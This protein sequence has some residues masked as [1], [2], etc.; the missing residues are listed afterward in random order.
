MA[1]QLTIN[2]KGSIT[3]PYVYSMVWGCKW[4]G[5]ITFSFG[6]G[7]SQSIASSGVDLIENSIDWTD[8]EKGAVQDVLHA[9]SNVCNINFIETL[10]YSNTATNLVVYKVTQA[11]LGTINGM[12]EVPDSSKNGTNTDYG[13]FN[14]N[15]PYW[16]DFTAGG[17]GF[18]LLLHEFGHAVGLAHPHDGGEGFQPRPYPGISKQS[19]TWQDMGSNFLNQGIWSTMSYN[20]G[21]VKFADGTDTGLDPSAD[22]SYGYQSTPMAFDV[23]A[24]Q[25]LYGANM[26]Y[27]TSND[28]YV[29]PGANKIGTSWACIWDAAGLDS[30]SNQGA[31]QACVIDLREAEL[32]N[33]PNGGGYVSHI[34]GVA[35]GYTIAHSALIENAIGGNG[36]DTLIGNVLSN[37]L[38][39]ND[40]ND[41]LTGGQGND[42]LDGGAGIDTATYVGKRNQYQLDVAG[43]TVAD[44]VSG[45]D[46][47]DLLT[48]IERIRF[49]DTTIGLDVG[50]GGHVGEVYRL[51]L[52]LLNRNFGNDPIGCGYWIDRLDKN[53]LTPEQ[54]AACFIN[55]TEFIANFGATT[56][57]DDAFVH[58][59][60]LNML[61]RDSHVDP[62][63]RFWLSALENH[64]ATREQVVAGFTESAE[65]VAKAA[66]II[67]NQAAFQQWE[68]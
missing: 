3:N 60:Y 58:M 53:M 65:C 16:V 14:V 15:S 67:G 46:G 31:F 55:S 32:T 27:R 42:R 19:S 20:N 66:V 4:S 51:Y 24:L 25:Y 23:A 63:S 54:V 34:E 40:G 1:T 9:Y 56:F 44:D 50:L 47:N 13:L 37:Q 12:F 22:Y 57:T 29:L 26:Q 11:V 30:I 8:A 6:S 17:S 18:E 52:A 41:S 68:G 38:T 7:A 36:A 28:T 35:G 2:N 39:A 45:R 21:W 48:S 62:D 10:S 61:N 43:N 64:L 49:S 59:L 33:S 5:D